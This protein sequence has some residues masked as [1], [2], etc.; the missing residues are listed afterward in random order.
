MT[1]DEDTGVISWPSPLPPEVLQGPILNP[2]NGHWYYLLSPMS[3]T[4][5]EAV[6]LELGGHL[7]TINDAAENEWVAGTMFPFTADGIAELWLGLNDAETEGTFLWASGEPVT[8]TNWGGDAPN[9]VFLPGFGDEDYVEMGWPTGRTLLWNDMHDNGL[10]AYGT[11]IFYGV[12]EA[13]HLPSSDVTVRVEDGRG[14]SDEQSFTIDV[15]G[16]RPPEIISEP[17]TTRLHRAIPTPTT[18]TRSIRT[19]DPLTYSLTTKPQG[20]TINPRLGIDLLDSRR[21]A[22]HHDASVPPRLDGS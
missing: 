9:N 11:S 14:G 7:A 6:A 13:D 2:A 20:M 17:V 3:W 8:Y 10:P 22:D 12:V 1:I 15:L 18:S 19:D 21:L 16:N 5:S 4:D